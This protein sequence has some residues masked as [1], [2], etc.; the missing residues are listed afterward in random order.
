M[1]QLMLLIGLSLLSCQSES[2]KLKES[3][4]A[5]SEKAITDAMTLALTSQ[6]LTSDETSIFIGEYVRLEHDSSVY[7]ANG[8][9]FAVKAIVNL[10]DSS[11]LKKLGKKIQH[12]DY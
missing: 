2:D 1:K 4:H 3:T 8:F 9:A 5:K 7:A 6:M 11:K 10:G 12:K